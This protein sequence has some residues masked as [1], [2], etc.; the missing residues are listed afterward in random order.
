MEEGWHPGRSHLS[1]SYVTL[2]GP[3]YQSMEC[4]E[5]VLVA[6]WREVERGGFTFFRCSSAMWREL[7]L[8]KR[9]YARHV[10]PAARTAACSVRSEI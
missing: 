10:M 4:L 5:V 1:V 2:R 7:A 6:V 8:I 9:S 3:L